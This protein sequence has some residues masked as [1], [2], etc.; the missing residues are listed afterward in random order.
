PGTSS[1]SRKRLAIR[2]R[3]IRLS[4]CSC[5]R[6]LA[7]A[8]RRRRWLTTYRDKSSTTTARSS[9][10]VA[11]HHWSE[12]L[13]MSVLEPVAYSSYCLDR[14]GLF[15]QIPGQRHDVHIDG[16]FGDDDIFALGFVNGALP[17][18]H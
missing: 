12:R 6:A 16:A 1:S 14:L 4:C 15:T 9:S 18:I 3:A 13:R 11:I 5:S 8:C 7:S 2:S 17:R 10:R